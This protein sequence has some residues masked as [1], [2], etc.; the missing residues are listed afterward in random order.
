MSPIILKREPVCQPQRPGTATMATGDSPH[1]GVERTRA[2][3]IGMRRH[4]PWVVALALWAAVLASAPTPAASDSDAAS[5]SSA[6]V[7][8]KEKT[9]QWGAA[10]KGAAH[11]VGAATQRAAHAVSQATVKGAHAVSSEAKTG[12]AKVKAKVHE[13]TAPKG[14]ASTSGH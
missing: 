9:H 13:K 4:G 14:A 7:S 8:L 5:S 12:Y 6:G 11:K 3:R 1:S 2:E 10:V